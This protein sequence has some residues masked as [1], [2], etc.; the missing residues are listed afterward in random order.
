MELAIV[1]LPDDDGSLLKQPS[2]GHCPR[3]LYQS[4][5]PPGRV[6]DGTGYSPD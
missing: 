1:S 2:H 5:R 6:C 3:G 4:R